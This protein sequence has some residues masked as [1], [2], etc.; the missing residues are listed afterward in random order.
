MSLGQKKNRRREL[1][2]LLD[3]DLLG[4]LEPGVEVVGK[5]KVPSGLLRLNTHFTGEIICEGLLVV[6]EEGEVEAD[7]QSRLVSISGKVKG[8]IHASERLEIKEHGVVLGDI[9]TPCLVIDPGGYF[10][11]QCRMPAP[12]P[13]SE[14]LPA[15]DAAAQEDK[16]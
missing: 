2:E 15:T 16:V 1:V 13:E 8:S 14:K 11:G 5:I 9:Y 6:A 10:D 12:A 7:I 4:L 3:H